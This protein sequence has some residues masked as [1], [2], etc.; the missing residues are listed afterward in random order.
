MG[1]DERTRAWQRFR[2]YIEPRDAWVG[3]YNSPAAVYVCPLPFVVIR[4]R[5]QRP[6][7]D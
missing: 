3:V 2:V 7:D 6:G 5:K 1:E 4:Y